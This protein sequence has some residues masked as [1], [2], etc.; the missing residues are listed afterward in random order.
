[1]AGNGLNALEEA[2]FQAMANALGPTPLSTFL[3]WYQNKD[4]RKLYWVQASIQVYYHIINRFQLNKDLPCNFCVINIFS[5]YPL[6]V[7]ITTCAVHCS[8]KWFVL[9]KFEISRRYHTKKVLMNFPW[10]FSGSSSSVLSSSGE[11]KFFDL[12]WPWWP[13]NKALFCGVATRLT[14]LYVPNL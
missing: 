7:Q 8:T 14:G 13:L 4:P 9:T 1:M 6:K 12:E 11:E 3:F 5:V 2:L 10:M